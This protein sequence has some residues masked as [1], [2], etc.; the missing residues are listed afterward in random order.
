VKNRIT[1]ILGVQHP[2]ILGPMRHMTLGAMAAAVSNSGG[3]GQIAASGLSAERLR[4]E[5]AAAS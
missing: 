1:E 3:F 2:F 4:A 5:I